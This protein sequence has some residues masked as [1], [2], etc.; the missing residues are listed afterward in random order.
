MKNTAKL[1]LFFFTIIITLILLFKGCIGVF[2]MSK[3]ISVSV[4]QTGIYGVNTYIITSEHDNIIID[5]GGD[6]NEIISM[7]D[8]SK[9]N[10]I[11]ITHS[12]FD[13]IGALNDLL[14]DLPSGT[15]YYAH[16]ICAER[17]CDPELNLSKTLTGAPYT[18]K[19]ATKTISDKEKILR[20][21]IQIEALHV[22]G[23]APGHLCYYL[24]SEGVLFSG[25][26]IFANGIG[27][28]DLPGGDTQTLLD[29]CRNILN[30][31][32]PETT[33]LSGHGPAT[34]VM[35]EKSSNPYL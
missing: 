21:D 18:G 23:H 13:H 3:E 7:I 33:I 31:L 2:L 16:K 12:H 27:R 32:P 8:T 17:V 35:R 22:P 26:T 19:P 4:I 11:L 20:G 6:S 28:T 30:I 9:N 5:P 15:E 10:L 1:L 34:T 24:Q 25:D 14:N 29:H